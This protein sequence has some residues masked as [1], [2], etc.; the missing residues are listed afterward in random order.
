M[1]DEVEVGQPLGTA[2]SDTELPVQSVAFLRDSRPAGRLLN[3][4]RFGG[5]L[6]GQLPEYRVAM[7]GRFVIFWPFMAEQDTARLD[8]SHYAE[9]LKR[10]GINAVLEVPPRMLYDRAKDFFSDSYAALYPRGEWAQVFFDNA[11]VVYLRRNPENQTIIGSH[12]YK[13][14]NRGLPP[15]LGAELKGLPA[16]ARLAFESELDRCI[17]ENPRCLYCLIGKASFYRARGENGRALDLL[18][19]ARAID[20]KSPDVLIVLASLY[21]SFGRTEEGDAAMRRFH[22]ETTA[23]PAETASAPSR[24]P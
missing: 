10:W 6:I 2:V 11:S 23:P 14:L 20:P 17:A 15:S 22:R 19:R 8:P 3:A 12:E 1:P 4:F 9:F 21:N 18:E 13:V 24:Q 7:D 16:E 5:Y